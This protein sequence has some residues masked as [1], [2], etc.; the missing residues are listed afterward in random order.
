MGLELGSVFCLLG[1]QQS[2]AVSDFGTGVLGVD[3]HG[4]FGFFFL[5]L[6][7]GSWLVGG[8]GG[9]LL[10]LVLSLSA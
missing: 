8:G 2:I 3:G 5:F 4:F 9:G 1:F 10:S 6:F 7:L